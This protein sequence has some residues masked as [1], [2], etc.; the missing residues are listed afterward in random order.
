MASLPMRGLHNYIV[1]IRRAPNKQSVRA[2]IQKE[3]A[4]IRD[5]FSA[6]RIS[7][8][9]MRKYVCKLM[10]TYLLGEDIDLGH[11]QITNLMASTEFA[12]KQIGYLACELLFEGRSDLVLLV[13]EQMRADIMSD[14]ELFQSLALSA[15]G[16]IGDE[17][18]ADVLTPVLCDLLLKKKSLPDMVVKKISL[19][20]L[21]FFQINN[22]FFDLDA[23]GERFPFLISRASPSGLMGLISLLT[24]IAADDPTMFEH[25]VI[26]VIGVLSDVLDKKLS[27]S[28]IY[29]RVPAPWLQYVCLR[30]LSLYT[31]FEDSAVKGHVERILT[32]ILATHTDLAEKN[33]NT[34]YGIIFSAINI[35]INLAKYDVSR[36]L[37]NQSITLLS[38]YLRAKAS[39]LRMMGI[40]GLR[41][42]VRECNVHSEV[43]ASFDD[44][45]ELLHGD[46]PVLVK[47]AVGL[48]YEA[49]TSRN[50]TKSI[51]VL[52][53]FIL[54]EDCSTAIKKDIAFK[55]TAMAETHVPPLVYLDT[56]FD[57][58]THKKIGD[59]LPESVYHRLIVIVSNTPALQTRILTYCVKL[60]QRPELNEMSLKLSSFVIGE[61]GD[62]TVSASSVL[63]SFEKQLTTTLSDSTIVSVLIS[64]AKMLT[65]SHDNI[66]DR[67]TKK[68]AEYLDHPS[69]NVQQTANEVHVVLTKAPELIG[70]LFDSIPELDMSLLE[71]EKSEVAVTER[72]MEKQCMSIIKKGE[73]SLYNN[74]NIGV[75][76]KVMFSG[77]ECRLALTIMNLS[78]VDLTDF[79][80][81]F[82]SND[83]VTLRF[84]NTPETSITVGESIQ[85]LIVGSVK[86]VIT[87]APMLGI[88]YVVD[89]EAAFETIM[90]PV[91]MTPFIAPSTLK[92][93]TFEVAFPQANL[94]SE[95]QYTCTETQ[96]EDWKKIVTDDW[97]IISGADKGDM[98]LKMGAIVSFDGRSAG[99]L[100]KAMFA[101]DKLIFEVKSRDEIALQVVNCLHF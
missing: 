87:K 14:D 85:V 99:V 48:I 19:C 63:E 51:S 90:L 45:F 82:S 89:G 21:R 26:D 43:E 84:Y 33:K 42:F 1:E 49:T 81:G 36:N 94:R 16:T 5:K 67:V 20:L 13:T 23:F 29:H 35:V 24:T 78:A 72:D 88:R 73:G 70:V 62:E 32:T 53:K 44:L 64:L 10:Y 101:D 50:V 12:D 52:H 96:F 95:Q 58:I 60:L 59:L 7:R 47:S 65:W 98:D 41:L 100:A 86:S 22:T 25:L 30:F 76:A 31:T 46:D 66:S 2:R 17:T 71:L 56:I 80:A 39:N 79:E 15:A 91:L 74:K 55:L 34:S 6:K 93:S 57:L 11:I 8:Y 37:Q 3:L 68:I 9:D 18:T 83:S 40:K 28:Y 4:H 61:F 69:I 77:T 54:E 97:Q 27:S 92:E 75:E 38:K